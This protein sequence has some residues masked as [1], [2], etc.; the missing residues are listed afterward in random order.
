MSKP[1]CKDCL[2]RKY[3]AR[4]CDVHVDAD[5]C[6]KYGTELCLEMNA[7]KVDDIHVDKEGRGKP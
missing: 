3:L 7:I 4:V 6:D 5:D 1:N 2:Y